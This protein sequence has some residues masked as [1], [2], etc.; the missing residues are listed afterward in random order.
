MYAAVALCVMF[1]GGIVLPDL[2]ETPPTLLQDLP[3]PNSVPKPEVRTKGQQS[4]MAPAMMA[5]PTAPPA[6]TRQLPTSSEQRQ[7][8]YGPRARLSTM[9]PAMPSMP[10]DPNYSPMLPPEPMA[11][12]GIQSQGRPAAMAGP[13]R[14][15]TGSGGYPPANGSGYNGGY[16]AGPIAGYNNGVTAGPGAA[17]NAGFSAGYN[18][19]NNT[20]SPGFAP[21]ASSTPTPPGKPY[22]NW[23]P[24]P[25]ISPY[26][27]MY[28]T[29]TNN[30]T[31]SPYYAG[32]VPAM[33][34]AQANQT[35]STQIGGLQGSVMRQDSQLNRLNGQEVP[36]GQGLANPAYFQNYRQYYPNAAQNIPPG[37]TGPQ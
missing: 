14:W 21:M 6:S 4:P 18:A 16:N 7:T 3:Q 27:N 1:A 20:V 11:T 19:G 32:V 26:M 30:G 31:V 37:M 12:G 8:P 25:A 35:F 13:R 34:Q 15:P 28:V 33:E 17:Y 36:M 22:Q 9:P 24:A 2:D 10:T 29:P 5:E 23:T